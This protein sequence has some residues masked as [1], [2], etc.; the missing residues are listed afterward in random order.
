MKKSK[1]SYVPD[2]ETKKR[3]SEIKWKK[4]TKNVDEKVSVFIVNILDNG[5]WSKEHYDKMNPELK[6]WFN[7]LVEAALYHLSGQDYDTFFEKVEAVIDET[8][9]QNIE[10]RKHVYIANCL[11]RLTEER[12]RFPARCEIVSETGYSHKTVNEYLEKYRESSI[13]RRREEELIILR[14][15]MISVCYQQGIGGDM[16]AARLF[17][18]ATEH[19][20]S[21]DYIKNEQNN[22]IQINGYCITGEQLKQ[23]PEEKQVQMQDILRL[24]NGS[25]KDELAHKSPDKD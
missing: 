14:E 25:S 22:F 4:G 6:K 7:Q 11:N 17:L 15:K 20:K 8:S 9:R 1:D 5:K 23:L 21:R 13:C 24:L 18:E 19:K 2:E 3:I 16:K 10:E 12:N